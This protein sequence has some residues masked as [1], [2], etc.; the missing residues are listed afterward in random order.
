MSELCNCI[1]FSSSLGSRKEKRIRPHLNETAQ[2][3]SATKAKSKQTLL[4]ILYRSSQAAMAALCVI[5]C[6]PLHCPSTTSAFNPVLGCPRPQRQPSPRV[7][8]RP[9]AVPV[10]ALPHAAG[11]TNG[12]G[13]RYGFGGFPSLSCE[14]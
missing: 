9:A 4:I 8:P 6:L 10:P 11:D 13:D 2:S 7:H 3:R 14:S 12:F 5:C 1:F